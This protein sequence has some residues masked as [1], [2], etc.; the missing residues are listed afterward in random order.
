MP[1]SSSRNCKPMPSDTMIEGMIRLATVTKNSALP[2]A[3]FLRNAS[4]AST[5]SA[6]V[7][8]M[9]TAPSIS[10]RRKAAP[11]STVPRPSASL[12]NQCSETPRSGKVRPPSGPWKL[13][14]KIVIIGP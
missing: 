10:E 9:T 8:S 6:T 11:M 12:R 4:P 14:T 13:S 7:K 5:E 2:P 1:L 3:S